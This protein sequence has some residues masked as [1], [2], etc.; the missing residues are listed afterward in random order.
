MERDQL[1][2]FP[3]VLYVA[4]IHQGDVVHGQGLLRG[5]GAGSNYQH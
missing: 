5:F 1:G 4:L 2:P 3:S